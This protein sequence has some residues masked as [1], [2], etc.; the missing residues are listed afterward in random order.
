M[1]PTKLK[2][3]K[4]LTSTDPRPQGT[5]E[6]TD[7]RIEVDRHQHHHHHSTPIDVAEREYRQRYRPVYHE[8][9][10]HSKAIVNEETVDGASGFQQQQPYFKETIKVTEET[11][12]P[13]RH[14][15]HHHHHPKMGY[16]DDDGKQKLL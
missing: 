7:T 8:G 3:C 1:S 12:E 15:H 11:V 2:L 14:H 5:T 9:Y 13:S 10:E 4:S 16:Y 6:Y